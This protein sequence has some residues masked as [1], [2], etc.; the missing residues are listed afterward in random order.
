MVDMMDEVT[1][2]EDAQ[3]IEVIIEFIELMDSTFDEESTARKLFKPLVTLASVKTGDATPNDV[4]REIKST[5]EDPVSLPEE[6][7]GIAARYR[8]NFEGGHFDSTGAEGMLIFEFPGLEGDETNTAVITVSNVSFFEIPDPIEVWPSEDIAP[9]LPSAVQVDLEYNGNNIS[10]FNF[11][12]AFTN[13]GL[14]T[15]INS[16]LY[17]DEFSFVL[18]MTHNPYSNASITSSFKHNDN[19]L[20]EVYVAAKGNWTDENIDNNTVTHYDTNYIWE[21][22][23]EIGWYETDEIEYIDDWVEVEVEEIL[24]SGNAHLIVMN[25]KMAGKV[26]V[27]SLGDIIRELEEDEELEDEEATQQLVD[28]LNNNVTLVAVYRDSNEK[29]ADLEFYKL[30]DQEEEDYY[31]DVR[32]IFADGSKVDAETYFEEGFDDL[33]N[34]LNDFITELNDQY[35]AEL[36]LIDY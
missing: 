16:T 19:L 8:W 13:D 10:S 15:N 6:W 18:N 7:E 30:Y 27:K 22:D 25:L 35:D 33:V 36:D 9:V 32:F 12:A 5:A 29:I 23:P 11:S 14:P 28:A 24:H 3:A 1:Q 20:A 34:A 4:I 26:N 31:M 21:W 17:V 2:L